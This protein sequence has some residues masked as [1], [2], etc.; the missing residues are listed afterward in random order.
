MNW[1]YGIG[2][3]TVS[4]VAGFGGIYLHGRLT[5][6]VKVLLAF[7]GAYLF[8]LAIM[9]LLP[10]I[11]IHLGHEAG[12]YVLGGFIIQM[13]MDYFSRGVEHGHVHH[14]LGDKMTFPL[15]L[16]I[17]LILHSIIEG[18]PLGGGF[19]HSHGGHQFETES[20]L[21]GLAIHK[22]PEAIALAAI[23]YHVF[24]KKKKVMV[25]VGIYA[26]ATPLGMFLGHTILAESAMDVTRVYSIIL[27]LAVGIFLHVSTTIIFEADEDHRLSW[28]KAL[29]IVLG[30]SLVI[31]L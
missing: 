27:S 29:A 13:V 17:S 8:A 28:R 22:I 1:Y 31:F 9:H 5:R 20:L 7:S 6:D 11:Y 2:L 21:V 19:D 18:L 12:Y 25:Y 16:F 23:L 26:L 30:L 4:L 10:E 14:H 3:F 24:A 15:S